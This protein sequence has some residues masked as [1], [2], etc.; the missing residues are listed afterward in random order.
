M[1]QTRL[2]LAMLLWVSLCGS[3]RA[4]DVPAG[5]DA[6]AAV[7]QSLVGVIARNEKSV[8]AVARVRRERPG[9]AFQFETR[10]D[11]FGRK[12]T[13]LAPPQPTDPDFVPNEYGA[14]VVV[15][16]GLVLT[17]TSLL[18]DES[19]YYVTTAEH[20]VYRATIKAA[21]PRSDLAV[22]A[23]DAAGLPPIGMGKADDVKRGQIVVSLGNPNAVA[24]DGQPSAS[25]GIIANLHR[26]APASPSETDPTGRPTLHHYGT[27]IQTD[28]R[29]NLGASGGPLLN[30][31]GEMIGLC[32]ALAVAPGAEVA[33]GYAMP[34]DATF[35]RA[36]ERLVRG[37]EVEYGFLGVQPANLRSQEVLSGLHGLRVAQLIPGTPA[38][39]CGLKPGDIITAV[40]GTP[41]YDSDGLIL[42]I[43]RLPPETVA[44]LTVLRNGQERAI[45]VV[46]SKYAVRGRK[47]VTQG[48]AP[49][50]GLKVDYATAVVD[51]E[52]RLPASLGEADAAV[53]VAEVAEKS[54][55]WQAGLRRGMLIARVGDARVATPK[56]FAAVVR[57]SA[58]PVQLR[59]VGDASPIRT[60]QPGT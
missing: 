1:R 59:L 2:F 8:V 14:G 51:E 34:V 10:V 15:A 29:L 30:L 3:L 7:E 27:L 60:V 40:D 43:G 42:N 49:W 9:E 45:A 20:K 12:L 52:G 17:V 11:A 4:Q 23:I 16:P 5:V 18:G 26:K 33:G 41:I 38:A 31:K 46:V 53:A 6:A 24:R 36:V 37:R 25:W 57:G 22:L 50:R 39:R 28:A 13:P 48:D 32:V 55:A 47:V 44:R 58:G 21:D 35:R 54:P 56:E 19:D